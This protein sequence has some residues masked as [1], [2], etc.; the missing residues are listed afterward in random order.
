M[1]YDRFCGTYQERAKAKGWIETLAWEVN[2]RRA[3]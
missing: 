1:Q 3:D 2:A